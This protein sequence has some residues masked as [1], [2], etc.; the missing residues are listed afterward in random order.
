VILIA[1]FVLA[2]RAGPA[3]DRHFGGSFSVYANPPTTTYGYYY[4]G[5]YCL[6]GHSYPIYGYPSYNYVS[7]TYCYPTYSYY[8]TPSYRPYYRPYY[9]PGP[10]VTFSW[11]DRM[12]RH[13]SRHR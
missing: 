10:N 1:L 9:Y 4:N 5:S 11:R 13:D 12:G 8:S 7:P 6:P 3:D 2:P